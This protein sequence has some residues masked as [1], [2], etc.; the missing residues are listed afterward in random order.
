MSLSVLSLFDGISAGITA[1][2]KC[3]INP[4]VYLASE[5][6]KTA[7]QISKKNWGIKLFILE[8]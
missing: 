6:D 8:M 7:I 4:D 3:N 1:L 5:V 2:K